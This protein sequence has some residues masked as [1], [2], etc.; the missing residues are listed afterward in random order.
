[1]E[2]LIFSTFI[3]G[4]GMDTYAQLHLSWAFYSPPPGISTPLPPRLRPSL[5]AAPLSPS[6]H[7]F[8]PSTPPPPPLSTPINRSS[9]DHLPAR[10]RGREL[11][12]QLGQPEESSDGPAAA[13]GFV[14]A[15]VAQPIQDAT[16]TPRQAHSGAGDLKNEIFFQLVFLVCFVGRRRTG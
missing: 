3:F 1:M 9:R 10:P 11:Q 5:Y 13:V 15:H 6:P 7:P 14:L 16:H 12:P 4:G 8:L 2:F